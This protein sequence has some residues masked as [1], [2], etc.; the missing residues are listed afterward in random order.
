MCNRLSRPRLEFAAVAF[1][2][3]MRRRYL[4]DNP[5]KENPVRK[6]EDYPPDQRSDLMAALQK[7]I[8]SASPEADRSFQAWLESRASQTQKG[9]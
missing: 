6:L 8:V 9:E 5:D 4:E 1:L 7:A 3:E 2:S